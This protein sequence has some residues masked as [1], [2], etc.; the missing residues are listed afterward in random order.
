MSLRVDLNCDLGESFGVYRF[1]TDHLLLKEI[2]SAN[3]A[4]GYH[5]GDHNVMYQ[6]IQLAKENNVSIG[7]HPG[8]QDLIGFGRRVIEI[9]PLEIYNLII[10][11]IGALM[12]FAQVHEVTVTHVKPHGALYNVAATNESV[13]N[14]IVNAVYDLN[15]ELILYGL[16]GSK[17]IHAGRTKGLKVAE[18]VFADR[19]YQADGT[20]TK[21]TL[22]NAMIEDVNRAVEQV[23]HMVKTGTCVA[24]DG[25]SFPIN[26]DTVCVHGDSPHALTFVTQLKERLSQHNISIKSIGQ[27][28]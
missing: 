2:T 27:D 7:A 5:A 21:R 1:G 10:Y 3:I 17:L 24:V 15:P 11:Q 12:G 22:P 13:A 9:D 14:A 16:A 19:T 23:I 28:V 4:C 26:A 18:E 25:T 8:Y 20:L 6:T